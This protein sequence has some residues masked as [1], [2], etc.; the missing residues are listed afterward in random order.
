[1]TQGEKGGNIKIRRKEFVGAMKHWGFDYVLFKFPDLELIFYP[2]K[3]MVLEVGKT[4]RK[5]KLT[6]LISFLPNEITYGFDHPDHNRTGEAVRIAGAMVL[7]K[8]PKLYFWTSLGNIT[9]TIERYYYL[10][11]F[12]KSQFKPEYLPILEQIGESYIKVR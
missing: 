4:I 6:V 12:Y 8:R 3:K 7:G 9:R 11:R 10:K 5:E 2:L 1:M